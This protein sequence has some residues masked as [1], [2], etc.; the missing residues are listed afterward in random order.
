MTMVVARQ[1]NVRHRCGKPTAHNQDS[2]F[3]ADELSKHISEDVHMRKLSLPAKL[4]VGFGVPLLALAIV[5]TMGIYCIH[6]LSLLSTGIDQKAGS[7]SCIRS[8]W[9]KINMR[10]V[11]ARSFLLSG[12]EK[13][14]R[15]YQEQNRLLN[16]KF[17]ELDQR[18]K[19][20]RGKQ[21]LAN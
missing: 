9:D 15:D 10:K 13:Y 21:M 18:M 1:G 4:A 3:S 11:D 8:A 14:M 6:Q 17:S 2:G 20:D 5:G 12:D 19:T 7:I 16:E